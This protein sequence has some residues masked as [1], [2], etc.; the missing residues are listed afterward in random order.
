MYI[1][2]D[3]IIKHRKSK[4]KESN[5]V[6]FKDYMSGMIGMKEITREFEKW[7]IAQRA[8]ISVWDFPTLGCRGMGVL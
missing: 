5:S 3:M 1:G 4:I 8:G 2:V 7:D 6:T